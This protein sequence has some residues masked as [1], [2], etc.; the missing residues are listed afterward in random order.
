[1]RGV[2]V[3]LA[4]TPHRSG[5]EVSVSTNVPPP[6]QGY[7]LVRMR[8]LAEDN[9]PDMRRTLGDSIAEWDWLEPEQLT[10]LRQQALVL[11]DP[12]VEGA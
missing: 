4:Y 12:R 3:P 11:V 2:S 7:D 8:L 1:V 6:P 9:E 10:L 5:A